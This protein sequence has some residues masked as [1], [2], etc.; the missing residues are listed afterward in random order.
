MKTTDFGMQKKTTVATVNRNSSVMN[1]LF[2]CKRFIESLWSYYALSTDLICT[3]Y[4]V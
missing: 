3:Y 4:W 2:C 1:I